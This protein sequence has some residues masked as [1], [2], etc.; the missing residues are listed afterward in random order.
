[1]TVEDLISVLRAYPPGALVVRH[2]RAAGKLPGTLC[3]TTELTPALAVQIEQTKWLIEG[4]LT[5]GEE[6][7]EVECL[8][9]D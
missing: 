9:L 2:A 7:E 5:R 8:I 3:L 1:M 4:R 6:G